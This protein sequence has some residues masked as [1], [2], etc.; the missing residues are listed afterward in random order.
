MRK[1]MVTIAGGRSNQTTR[2]PSAICAASKPAAADRRGEHDG[3]DRQPR[4]LNGRRQCISDELDQMVFVCMEAIPRRQKQK[5]A[6][7]A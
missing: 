4:F 7:M 1:W 3:I 5:S 2:A 6:G